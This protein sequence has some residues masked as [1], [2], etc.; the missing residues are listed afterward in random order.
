MQM[1]KVVV[2]GLLLLA[3]LG[4]SLPYSVAQ[5]RAGIQGTVLDQQ[6]DSVPAATVTLTNLET[7]KTQNLTPLGSQAVG[8]ITVDPATHTQTVGGANGSFGV[9]NTALAGRIIEMQARFSF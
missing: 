6:G 1:G 7:N 5:Y 3:V 8:T 4:L 9:V 2:R